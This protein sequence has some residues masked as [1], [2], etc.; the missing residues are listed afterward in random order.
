MVEVERI[1]SEAGSGM[2]STANFDVNDLISRVLDF[3][4]SFKEASLGRQRMAVDVEGFNFSVGKEGKKYDFSV[5]VNLSFNP[6][7]TEAAA[8]QPVSFP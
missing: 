7:K 8:E 3:V 4:D 2:A 6:K 5:S 1:K